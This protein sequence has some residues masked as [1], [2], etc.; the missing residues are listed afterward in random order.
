M[1]MKPRYNII[2]EVKIPM[3]PQLQ[4]SFTLEVEKLHCPSFCKCI[5]N[6]IF[7]Q[8][9]QTKELQQRNVHCFLLTGIL[10]RRGSMVI[11]L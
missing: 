11:C 10:D 8:D 3:S 9:F 1:S 7:L 6:K 5:V 2:K 4:P